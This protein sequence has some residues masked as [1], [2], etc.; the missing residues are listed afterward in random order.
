MSSGKLIFAMNNLYK[1]SV[2]VFVML[3][4]SCATQ[5]PVSAQ[6]GY[7]NSQVFYDQLSPYGEWVDYPNY[8][9][10]WLPDVDQDF[11]PYSTSGYWVMTDYGWTWVSDYP[12]G[13]AP[14][15]YGRWDYDDYYGWFW[16]PDY[17]WGPSWVTWRTGNGYYGW[18]PMRPGISISL[19]F[20]NSYYDLDR[21]NFV[22]DRDFGREDIYRYYADRSE[23]NTIIV[24][25]TVINNTY[26]DRSRNTTYI[27]G[28]SRNDVQRVT[29]RRVSNISIRDN[30]RPGQTLKNNQ[31]QIY[32]PQI[33]KTNDQGRKPA[34]VRITNLKD[35]KPTRERTAP[36]QRRNVSPTENNRREQQQSQPQRQVDRQRQSQ[37]QQQ[38]IERRNQDQQKQQQQQQ[39]QVDRQRQSQQNQQQIERRNQEQQNQQNQEQQKVERQQQRQQQ[40]QQQ[41]QQRQ[42]QRNQE[43]QKVDRQQQQQQQQQQQNQQRQEQQP[44][45]QQQQSERQNQKQQQK[46]QQ[47]AQPAQ[48]QQQQ[49]QQAQPVQQQQQQQQQN[50][51]QP[52]GNKR[53]ERQ[54]KAA[55]AREKKNEQNNG[56][57]R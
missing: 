19:S 25:S 13:W 40:Q 55:A 51:T 43:K 7:V 24:N 11:S 26:I 4:Y 31:L 36:D 56:R 28:P 16:V 27:A 41:N 21:W 6:G 20:G 32:R 39:K 45:R 17:E 23:Y 33:Q 53:Q 3:S 52:S 46:Q 12:W 42:E 37:Q 18:T 22:R 34:P 57:S 49:Q 44:N 30:D 2:V 50:V 35:V 10:V 15:H 47:Q 29:G 54:Q 38:Q 1:I 8:G 14:F 9:Y 48:Q 5:S